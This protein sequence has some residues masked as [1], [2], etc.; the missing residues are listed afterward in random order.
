[1]KFTN[2]HVFRDDRFTVGI[3]EETGKYYLGIP[4]SNPYV[5]YTEYYEID[6]VQFQA[7]PGNI[8]ELRRIVA[9]CRAREN[10]DRLIN[11]PGR[12]RGDPT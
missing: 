10:D 9:R 3:E 12:L 1:M 5:D 6:T 8:E 11:K 2:A 7:C 4:V